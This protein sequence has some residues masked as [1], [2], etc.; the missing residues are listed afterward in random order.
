MHVYIQMYTYVY[1]CIHIYI[2]TIYICVYGCIRL[3][4]YIWVYTRIQI[5]DIYFGVYIYTYLR[6][7]FWCIHVYI[8]DDICFDVHISAIR[9][10]MYTDIRICDAYVNAYMYIHICDIYIYT[11][12]HIYF[13]VHIRWV[14]CYRSI[15][16]PQQPLVSV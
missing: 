1:G 12:I 14:Q 15:G 4:T 3:D 9:I 7:I 5:C 11:Y 6:Y 2:T 13:D 8:S 10:L 16:A